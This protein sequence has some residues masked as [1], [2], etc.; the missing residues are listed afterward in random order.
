MKI[1]Y[2]HQY[3]N[4]ANSSGGT[5]S[6]EFA[7]RLVNAGHE[8]HV[9]TSDRAGSS[10]SKDWRSS[11]IDGITVHSV[12]QPYDNSMKPAQRLKAFLSF[13]LRASARGRSLNADVVFATST[14]LTIA[15]PAIASTVGRRVPLVMEIRDLWPAVPIAMG[16]L[17]NP[18]VRFLASSLETLAYRRSSQIIALSEGMAEGIISKG[19]DKSEVTVIPNLSDT[20]R[21]RRAC[22]TADDFYD[23]HPELRGRPFL[24][25]TG[26]FGHVNGVEYM[27]SLAKHYL[28]H[29]PNL[30]FVAMGNG[31][32][33]E[34][35]RKFSRALGVLDKNFFLLDPVAKKDL[36]VV[37]KAAAA[38]SSWVIPVKE[39][40]ANSANK[41][42]DAL[43]AGRPMII[44]HGGWQRE[45]LHSSG[46]GLSLPSHDFAAAAALLHEKLSDEKW[47]TRA[48][49]ASAKLGEDEFDVEKSFAK[50][51][52][53]LE[54]AASAK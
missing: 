7:R 12:P 53:V 42:F 30:A 16:Y 51:C 23:N 38:C 11:D 18:L 39:L 17:K 31:A 49:A 50:F 14:P 3:F 52:K 25:Y 13:A 2:L 35:V 36:P 34:S 4:T 8:V 27:A 33:K 20:A 41:F 47:M 32:K 15:I 29:D 54:K 48:C 1:V 43:A 19:V 9:V 5:R 40:E 44:N 24:V 45:L 28:D 46:A 10:L 26:T 6:Y 21:F 22:I 37:L